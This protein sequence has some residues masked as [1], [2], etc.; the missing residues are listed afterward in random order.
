MEGMQDKID[1]IFSR[2]KIPESGQS[3]AESNI[4]EK[5]RYIPNLSD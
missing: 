3:L 1:D 2:I 4:I 5:L